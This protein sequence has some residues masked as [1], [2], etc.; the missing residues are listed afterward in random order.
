MFKDPTHFVK[1]PLYNQEFKGL[2]VP[3]REIKDDYSV[4]WLYA[5]AN[6]SETGTTVISRHH[7]VIIDIKA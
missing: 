1:I 3:I 4:Y 7:N 2:F 6:I 5:P